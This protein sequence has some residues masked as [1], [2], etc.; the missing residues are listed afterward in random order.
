MVAEKKYPFAWDE[1]KRLFIKCTS[2]GNKLHPDARR[3]KDRDGN[4]D[5]KIIRCPKCSTRIRLPAAVVAFL[6]KQASTE[7]EIGFEPI[8]KRRKIQE[9]HRRMVAD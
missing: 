6:K 5:A 8:S 9:R 1:S 4:I 3:W 2:C 7:P